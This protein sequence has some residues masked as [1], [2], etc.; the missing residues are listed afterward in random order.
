MRIA[1]VEL[2]DVLAELPMPKAG[3]REGEQTEGVHERVDAA[4]AKA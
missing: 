3:G 2:G 4:V 1:R